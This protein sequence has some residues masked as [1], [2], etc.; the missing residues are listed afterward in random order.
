MFLRRSDKDK[1]DIK[2]LFNFPRKTY[3]CKTFSN[4]F[5]K[6]VQGRLQRRKYNFIDLSYP[7]RSRNVTL[8][9]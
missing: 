3:K 6:T 7:N 8:K 4:V 2:S 5:I 9:K 1:Y